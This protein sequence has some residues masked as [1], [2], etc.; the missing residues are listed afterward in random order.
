MIVFL[1]LM[2]CQVKP[3]FRILYINSRNMAV[4]Q[5]LRLHFNASGAFLIVNPL[6]RLKVHCF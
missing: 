4:S 1:V 3:D 6:K 5:A 2:A